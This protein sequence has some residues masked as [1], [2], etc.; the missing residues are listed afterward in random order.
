MLRIKLQ[1]V[2]LGTYTRNPCFTSLLGYLPTITRKLLTFSKDFYFFQL[3]LPKQQ[4]HLVQNLPLPLRITQRSSLSENTPGTLDSCL[5]S[6]THQKDVYKNN[7]EV[8][9]M[10]NACHMSPFSPKTCFFLGRSP[11]TPPLSVLRTGSCCLLVTSLVPRRNH[12]SPS[13]ENWACPVT[14]GTL[15][16]HNYLNQL[17]CFFYNIQ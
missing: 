1:H 5:P 3:L 11:Q 10:T 9:A 4:I 6:D 8:Q 7:Q 14:V 16:P 12:C 2:I 17:V 15:L 13:A